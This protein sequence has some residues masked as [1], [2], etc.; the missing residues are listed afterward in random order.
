MRPALAVLAP[1][2]FE[3]EAGLESEMGAAC[4]RWPAAVAD[5]CLAAMGTCEAIETRARDRLASLVA[6]ARARSP[7]YREL[8]RDIEDPQP[9][10]S[11][12]PVVTRR[13][14]MARFD[15]WVTDAKIKRSSVER[16]VADVGNVG[17]ALLGR[18]A[19]WK[20]SGTTFEPGL[21]LHDAGALAIYDAL[22]CVRLGSGIL[23]PAAALSTILMGARYAMVA[24]TGGHYAGV[25]SIE[26]LR[27]LAPAMSES[28]RVFSL[29]EPLPRL[30]D[31][32][33]DWRPSFVATHPSV[34]NVLATEQSA[35]RLRIQ[36]AAF[37]L[38]GENLSVTQ[39]ESISRA[40]ECTV[41]EQY[42]A[43]ECLSIACECARG[44]L[45]LN[46][47]WVMLEPV[48]REFRPVPPGVMSHTVLLTN[49]AN[50]VQPIIRYD[51]GDS[52]LIEDEPCAC[53]SPLP[54]LRVEGRSDEIIRVRTANGRSVELLPVALTTLIEE[55]MAARPFQV[56]QAGANVLNLRIENTRDD[57]SAVRRDRAYRALR[58]H[59]DAQGL[60]NVSIQHDV[61]PVA[62]NRRSGKL[63]RIVALP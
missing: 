57:E 27:L 42:G 48:D 56:V 23:G 37:W 29:F 19:V 38:G 15:D 41:L 61:R 62:V 11:S 18:Y 44:A 10:L 59:L 39:R 30:V 47:D 52:V 3:P 1:H 2:S 5:A 12:L 9:A 49:L 33:N 14:L 53:G 21:F 13:A 4:A 43:S 36:P 34:A 46:A 8:Y 60:S 51:L 7:Y 63:Q 22:D 50:R 25:A 40:F 54:L 24:A 45:H 31:A 16:F 55:C 58:E 6:S 26:R 20:S 32:L 35:G 28:L 17:H